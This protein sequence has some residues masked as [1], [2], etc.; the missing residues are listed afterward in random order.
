VATRSL[1]K[2]AS[3]VLALKRAQTVWPTS[4]CGTL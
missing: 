1:L 2:N 3:T 4:A